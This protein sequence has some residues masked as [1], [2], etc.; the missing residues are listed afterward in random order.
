MKDRIQTLST[1]FIREIQWTIQQVRR[2]VRG[3]LRDDRLPMDKTAEAVVVKTPSGGIEARDGTTVKSALCDLYREVDGSSNTKTLTAIMEGAS[4]AQVRVWNFA[5]E[6][7]AG[8]AYVVTSR[9]K[10]GTRYV[11]VESCDSD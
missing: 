7:V 5:N 9:T 4:P 11:V 10:S 6:A 8:D 1:E 2:M 3:D